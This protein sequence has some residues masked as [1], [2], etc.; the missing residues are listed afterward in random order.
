MEWLAAILITTGAFCVFTARFPGIYAPARKALR[1]RAPKALTQS[2]VLQNQLAEKIEPMLELDPIKRSQTEALLRNLGHTE[3][4]ELF[5]AQA[6]A[7]SIFASALCVVFLLFSVPLGV[8][9]M[10]L[11]GFGYYSKRRK[12][13]EK[14]LARKRAA[15]ERELPQFAATIRQSLGTTRDVVSILTS[16]R[17]VCGQTLAG[18]IDKTLNDIITG[19]AEQ[20]IRAL[21]SR[22]ASPK[23][24]QLTRGLLAVLRGDDQRMYFDV[25]A[26]EYRKSQDEEVDRELLHRPQKLYPYMGLM[27]SG[28]ILMLI[29]SLGAEILT[30][31]HQFFG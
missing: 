18:E 7:G 12:T 23:L 14:E 20:A 15:I 2:Q 25:L 10:V 9:D 17:R 13:L 22:V 3:S 6:L 24:G 21:E 26:E 8:A 28:F 19:N 5:H 31:I 16:Y 4:P 11:V 30:Q 29:A 1:F 27:F